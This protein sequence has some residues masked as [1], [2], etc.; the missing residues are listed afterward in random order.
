MRFMIFIHVLFSSL[1]LFGEETMVLKNDS[2]EI[3]SKSKDP[4]IFYDSLAIKSSRNKVTDLMYNLLITTPAQTQ[5]VD[6]ISYEYYKRYQNM[7]I[8]SIR[9]KALDVF[10][11]SLLDTAKTTDLWIEKTANKIHTK[12]NLN[13]I[14]KNLWIKEG[15]PFDP[16]LMMDNER[17]L[18]SL[19]YLQDVRIIITQNATN[20]NKID[21]LVITKDVFSFGVSASAKSINSGSIGLYDQNILGRGHEIGVKII[22][23]TVETP[24]VGFDVYYK[25]NNIGG[26]FFDF[27]SG[28]MNNY[29]SQGFFV[30]TNRDFLRPQT[31]YAGGITALRN[32]RSNRIGLQDVVVTE[33]PLDYVYLDLW[34][35]RRL[36]RQIKP[37]DSRFQINISGKFR[38]AYFYDRP[39]PDS[40]NNQYFSNSLL[41]LGS[42]S[43]SQRSYVRDLLVYSY[44]ITEDVPKGYLHELVFGYDKNENGNRFYSHAFFSTGNLFRSQPFYLYSSF[45]IGSYWNKSGPEQ[46][47]I[48][49]KVNYISDLYH[50]RN[51]KSRFFFKANYTQGINRYDIESLNL[52]TRN[53]IRGFSR[54]TGNGQ[55]R[56]TFSFEN[57]F[58]LKKQ[59][60]NFQT[61]LFTFY[62]FALIGDSGEK[63]FKEDYY[64]GLG[65]GIRVRNEHLVFKTIQFRLTFYPNHPDGL[66]P[67]GYLIDGVPKTRFYSF[68]PNEPNVLRFE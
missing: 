11:P 40:V 31:V 59:F 57:V 66:S 24:N 5:N 38:Y 19:S 32:F 33:Y 35:G 21:I 8:N 43:F 23:H 34:Y 60:L 27:S 9:I 22:G 14:Q 3:N 25:V 12:S 1:C 63:I 17:L 26:N 51:I 56:L 53:G 65:I 36:K 48:D 29:I 64:S 41:T 61:A 54:N 18:R 2:I 45:G 16:E 28:Y 49:F 37:N 52:S 6:L 67:F 13:V 7:I 30:N 39:G 50:F 58:F 46:G 47:L 4:N 42:I 62:D 15:H 68:Q 10:G 20:E 44:G 55:Q